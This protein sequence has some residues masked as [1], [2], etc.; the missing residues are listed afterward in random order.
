MKYLFLILVSSIF[1]LNSCKDNEAPEPDIPQSLPDNYVSAI[2]V[3]SDGVKYFATKKGLS[4]FD[5]S[6][7]KV[8]N[9]NPKVTVEIING[10]GFEKTSSSEE[11]WLATNKGINVA[12]LPVDAI[13]G[14]TTYTK[15]N[16]QTLFPG[17]PGLP[18]DSVFKVR[19]DNKNIRWFGTNG[20][21]SAFQ[22]SK[23]PKINNSNHYS[24]D[25]FVTNR[26]TGIDYTGDTIYIA[27]KGGGIARMVAKNVDAITAASP[28]EIPWSMLPSQNVLC[29]FTDGSTQWYG[30]D[31]GLARHKGTQAKLN[32]ETFYV[33]DGLVSN[34][35]QC[36]NKDLSEKMWF[37]TPS[38]VTVFNGTNW[39]SYTKADG[40][41]DNNVLCI[42]VDLNGTVW[43]GTANGV[44]AF[45]GTKW[46]N[47]IAD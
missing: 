8:Y 34:T 19:I 7:W 6:T 38:G 18:G 23:W 17:S 1:V 36:I 31:E 44:S 15:S 3:N 16:T 10:L 20:G 14:A 37:G 46:T 4:S 2:F 12:A 45:D 5:G 39:K 30:T 29:V 9:K 28:Y 40:L 35:V 25:F 32:W 43:F 47:Y 27:T 22:G 11:L 21:L 42:A 26:I 33:T 24:N 41:V 13:S